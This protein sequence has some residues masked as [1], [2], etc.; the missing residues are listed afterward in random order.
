MQLNELGVPAMQSEGLDIEFPDYALGV[1]ALEPLFP[2]VGQLDFHRR[3]WGLS[4]FNVY[5]NLTFMSAL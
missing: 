1:V 5:L 2:N 3:H 4:P